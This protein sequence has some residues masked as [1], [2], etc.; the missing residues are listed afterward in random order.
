LRAVPRSSDQVLVRRIRRGDRQAAEILAER[1]V[2]P[3]YRLAVGITG[4]PELAEDAVQDAF[5]RAFRKLSSYDDTRPFAPWLY[6][7]VVNRSLNLVT[8]APA[9]VELTEA[10]HQAVGPSCERLDLVAA[11]QSLEPDKRV[12]VLMRVVLGYSPPETAEALGV[13]VGTVH[14]RLSRALDE[15]RELLQGA[16]P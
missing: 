8:R 11:L 2:R 4:R 7:I 5:E 16:P 14:S 12:V 10:E 9:T 13:A 3:A 6:R 1:H 15:L